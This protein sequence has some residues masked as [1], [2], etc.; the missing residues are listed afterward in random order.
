MGEPGLRLHDP[1]DGD[2]SAIDAALRSLGA[3]LDDAITAT[4][5]DCGNF[6]LLG[7]IGEGGYG[8]GQDREFAYLPGGG[9]RGFGFDGWS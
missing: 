6:R 9:R 8:T 5:G 7:I 2:E 4:R 1:D 3:E